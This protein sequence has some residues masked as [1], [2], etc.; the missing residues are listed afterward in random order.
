M[1][2]KEIDCQSGASWRK[3][4]SQSITIPA[5]LPA[6][7]EADSA[8]LQEVTNR[9]PMRINPYYLGL[10]KEPGDPIY[11]QCI[12]D[13]REISDKAGVDDPL[14]E[15]GDSPVPGLTHRYADRALFL[16]SSRCAMYC[17]FCNRK[18]KVGRTAMV[19]KESV[20]EGLSYIRGH[21]EI[22]D[23]LLS[24]GDPLLLG[25]RELF[26]ILT[27]LRAIPHVEIIRIGT[28]IPCTLPQRITSQLSNMLGG[29]MPLYIN[30]HFNHP[31]EIT[32]ESSLACNRLADAGIPLGCQTVLL[33]GVNDRPGVM[34]ALMQKLLTIRVRPYYLFQA[35][36]TKG[37]SHFWTPLSKGLEIMSALQGHTSGLCV[38][39]FA[40][41]LLGG[42]GKVPLLPEYV[43]G[44]DGHVLVARNYAGKTYRHPV[45]D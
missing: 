5:D 14:N 12:P 23:V 16:I 43:V 10:V 8:L 35:D 25:N 33:R 24:G 18:R 20:R 7:I 15:E 41:D 4:L 21:R 2:A 44:R 6:S 32:E 22:R 30:T 9:Y 28:R 17:R 37:T 34:T 45:L 31:D 27:E 38:P 36:P 13:I 29:F 19:T 42:G 26:R 40:V 11:R 39:H 3:I 1:K